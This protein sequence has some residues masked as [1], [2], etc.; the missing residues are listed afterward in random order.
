MEQSIQELQEAFRKQFQQAFLVLEQKTLSHFAR[1]EAH[2]VAV[3]EKKWV[4]FLSVP[5]LLAIMTLCVQ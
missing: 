3:Q 1:V 4:V 5:T 2:E